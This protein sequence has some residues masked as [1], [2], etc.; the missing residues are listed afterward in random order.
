[1]RQ[2]FYDP[3]SIRKALEDFVVQRKHVREGTQ[4]N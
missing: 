2:T 4:V 3:G 1:M